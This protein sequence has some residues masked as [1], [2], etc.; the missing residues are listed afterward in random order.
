[1]GYN[2]YDQVS[3]KNHIVFSCKE[4]FQKIYVLACI[5]ALITNLL[6]S[7]ELGQYFKKTSKKYVVL[8]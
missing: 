3:Q 5:L 7:W 6:K 1:M 2:T 4:N 8:F